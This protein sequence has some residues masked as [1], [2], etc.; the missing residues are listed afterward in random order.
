[1]ANT[2]LDTLKRNFDG[3]RAAA[4]EALKPL[5]SPLALAHIEWATE[6]PKT[7]Y[8]LSFQDWGESYIEAIFATEEAAQE[9]LANLTH[10]DRK[11]YFIDTW[12][13]KP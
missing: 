8:V 10:K 11:F 1:V 12:G 13:V 5:A 3:D 6:A 2:L 4:L 9:A 7:V